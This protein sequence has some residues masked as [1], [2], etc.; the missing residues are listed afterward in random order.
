MAPTPFA[1]SSGQQPRIRLTFE[2][3][4]L[5]ADAQ[6]FSRSW[7]LVPSRLHLI[8]DLIQR[9]LHEFPMAASAQPEGIQLLVDGFVLPPLQ[10]I[11]LLRDG[12]VVSVRR[13]RARPAVLGLSAEAIITGGTLRLAGD[14]GASAIIPLA[15]PRTSA[16]GLQPQPPQPA[17]P[18]RLPSSS[19]NSI[20]N[21]AN[22]AGAGVSCHSHNKST[23]HKALMSPAGRAQ[24]GGTGH[25]MDARVGSDPDEQGGGPDGLGRAWGIEPPLEATLPAASG[26]VGER[27]QALAAGVLPDIFEG[28]RGGCA[29]AI[30]VPSQGN[31]NG[32]GLG[33]LGPGCGP[34]HA[35]PHRG[36]GSPRHSH[37]K[38][39][40]GLTSSPRHGGAGE[41]LSQSSE[42]RVPCVDG[43]S[44]VHRR[45]LAPT[46]PSGSTIAVLVGC[47][48]EKSEANMAHPPTMM[49]PRAVAGSGPGG[50]GSTH[51]NDHGFEWGGEHR[52]V[53]GGEGRGRG[54]GVAA[55]ATPMGTRVGRILNGA[56]GSV[57]GQTVSS[58]QG[59]RQGGRAR[60]IA[61]P[62]PAMLAGNPRGRADSGG[63][64]NDGGDKPG[65]RARDP[66]AAGRGAAG[67]LQAGHEHG[68]VGGG[69]GGGSAGAGSGGRVNQD[70]GGLSP[71]VQSVSSGAADPMSKSQQ[72]AWE[73]QGEG[74]GG[75]GGWVK[76]GSASVA[77]DP[78]GENEGPDAGVGSGGAN[79]GSGNGS[80]LRHGAGGVNG[81]AGGGGGGGKGGGNGGKNVNANSNNNNGGEEEHGRKAGGTAAGIMDSSAAAGHVG[82]VAGGSDVIMGGDS[83]SPQGLW[84]RGAWSGNKRRK[85]VD[86]T[87]TPAEARLTGASGGGNVGRR[88]RHRSP[89]GGDNVVGRALGQAGGDGP[90]IATTGIGSVCAHHTED[91]DEDDL[92]LGVKAGVAVPAAAS[93]ERG[94]AEDDGGGGSSGM[95]AV[96]EADDECAGDTVN[97]LEGARAGAAACQLALCHGPGHGVNAAGIATGINIH[98][99]NGGVNHHGLNAGMVNHGVNA[100]MNNHG[101][102]AGAGGAAG[103]EGAGDAGHYNH[104]TGHYNHDMGAHK[105]PRDGGHYSHNDDRGGVGPMDDQDS[106]EK[107]PPAKRRRKRWSQSARRSVRGETHDSGARN[108][109]KG[110]GASDQLVRIGGDH[111][112]RNGTRP[113]TTSP[114]QDSVVAGFEEN[115][116][117]DSAAA[118]TLH[119]AARNAAGGPTAMNG[120]ATV[121]GAVAA[122]AKGAGSG[123]TR[124]IVDGLSRAVM[125]GA[126]AAAS[127]ATPAVASTGGG[128]LRVGPGQPPV[129]VPG[130][131]PAAFVAGA[132][133]PNSRSAR[134]KS[135][136]RRR[137]REMAERMLGNVGMSGAAATATASPG[138]VATGTLS[139]NPGSGEAMGGEGAASR[140]GGGGTAAPAPAFQGSGRSPAGVVVAGGSRVA[141]A[142]GRDAGSQRGGA[143]GGAPGAYGGGQHGAGHGADTPAV[144]RQAGTP[145]VTPL[146]GQQQRTPLQGQQ[147]GQHRQGGQGADSIVGQSPNAKSARKGSATARGAVVATTP[148]PPAGAGAQG[149]KQTMV[150]ASSAFEGGDNPIGHN[151]GVLTPNGLG[152]T[153]QGRGQAAN[154]VAPTPPLVLRLSAG[155]VPRHK[156]KQKR[157]VGVG[158]LISRGHVRFMSSSDEEGEGGGGADQGAD[159]SSSGD[160]EEDRAGQAGGVDRMARAAGGT[161]QGAGAGRGS[162]RGNKGGGPEAWG[163]VGDGPRG[164]DGRTDAV[165][166]DGGLSGHHVA[167]A[168]DFSCFPEMEAGVLP[169]VGAVV[170]FRVVE[171]APDTLVPRL[172]GYEQGQV[173]AFDS[174]SRLVMLRV[175]AGVLGTQADDCA[176]SMTPGGD[177]RGGGVQ[178]GLAAAQGGIV[179]VDASILDASAAPREQ[180]AAAQV[181]VHVEWDSLFQVRLVC[182]GDAAGDGGG[183]AAD[184]GGNLVDGEG[185]AAGHHWGAA[186][187][188]APA[189]AGVPQQTDGLHLPQHNGH[190]LLHGSLS[191]QPHAGTDSHL[192][193]TSTM[194]PAGASLVTA[195]R[196]PD[197]SDALCSAPVGSGPLHS[198]PCPQSAGV[199]EQSQKG[200]E[201][202]MGSAH[203]MRAARMPVGCVGQTSS[204]MPAAMA[205]QTHM[206]VLATDA[207]VTTHV[208]HGSVADGSIIHGSM[209]AE[210]S[211]WQVSSMGCTVASSRMGVHGRQAEA[212][213]P[214]TTAAKV[215]VAAVPAHP[216]DRWQQISHCLRE[217]RQQL[218]GAH[219]SGTGAGGQGDKAPGS[220]TAPAPLASAS[221]PIRE[222]GKGRHGDPGDADGAA[223]A[224]P[225]DPA[226]HPAPSTGLP[227]RDLGVGN[228][229][230]R[231]TDA[232]LPNSLATDEMPA[233]HHSGHAPLGASVCANGMLGQPAAA[234]AVA[235]ETPAATGHTTA[236]GKAK[237]VAPP[238]GIKV[239]SVVRKHGQRVGAVGPLLRMLQQGNAGGAGAT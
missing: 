163:G 108:P 37:D 178:G 123:G 232:G 38:I 73:A 2:A 143:S 95:A 190:G 67:A 66:G 124:S 144:A 122:H 30:L 156:K 209:P 221:H 65:E 194:A 36:T 220:Q 137:R 103:G 101:V 237:A 70:Y 164:G 71:H 165:V 117:S 81:N 151:A 127:G 17:Q 7:Y 27:G 226:T 147:V 218:Q 85:G 192:L 88:K 45:E 115:G 212:H 195:G 153:P 148:P 47:E 78:R 134:R 100:G 93:N 60:G 19:N 23:S 61:H 83:T 63:G 231:T 170:A 177:E 142:A 222:T 84:E 40:G 34:R 198:P 229:G 126:P 199:P 173:V 44:A 217:R 32:P 184:G 14:G 1:S 20:K 223:S 112:G 58:N 160:E 186:K 16:G 116:S 18:A 174:P 169:S 43:V 155:L 106:S 22:R 133:G 201:P 74:G 31:G 238:A 136:K 234:G 10:D 105:D 54:Q 205:E 46:R 91:E 152:F 75:R 135:L 102:N 110:V 4:L 51:H 15:V 180:D 118:A 109:A 98:G 120:R 90:A 230:A 68:G 182:A 146:N 59:T 154:A 188:G 132:R 8:G 33:R 161:W 24:G 92:D 145:V 228:P 50:V 129:P 131:A 202:A 21:N 166:V 235:S 87:A 48:L 168:R 49:L 179:G 13:G 94:V 6:D 97:S 121:T 208:A 187:E 219:A 35:E 12:D 26:T 82:G 189:M 197:H 28:S 39:R 215:T 130:V 141:H 227:A 86:A 111:P 11:S 25:R 149:A 125:P 167:D 200:S 89:T 239:A 185:H 62:E 41:R 204:E 236:F 216:R 76:S 206:P 3:G 207:P 56:G 96:A 99:F 162:R 77:H 214:A 171:M 213:A 172:S 139:G 9:L 224:S 72:G 138:A 80:S 29:A 191:A 203:G 183:G 64:D 53:G 128:G 79:G 193:N 140:G 157:R 5:E 196:A 57:D 225:G 159:A 181:C 175:R 150:A 211:S 69:L 119:A 107:P 176:D 210:S 104:D 114:G 233:N 158:A 113:P 52:H 55:A 42:A